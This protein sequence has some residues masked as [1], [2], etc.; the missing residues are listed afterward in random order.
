MVRFIGERSVDMLHP[1]LV[2]NVTLK[3]IKPFHIIALAAIG[4]SQVII[5]YVSY[6]LSILVV[7]Y[8]LSLV[9]IP[10]REGIYDQ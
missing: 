5:I 6:P 7:P 10:Y 1:L 9:P 8:P 4:F 2:S 3:S